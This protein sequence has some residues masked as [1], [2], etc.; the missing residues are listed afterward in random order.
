MLEAAVLRVQFVSPLQAISRYDLKSALI[1]LLQ[2]LLLSALT[3]LP[4]PVAS[5]SF[6]LTPNE[7]ILSIYPNGHYTGSFLT[8]SGMLVHW[9]EEYPMF[10]REYLAK[11]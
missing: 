7:C 10:P 3:Q 4:L 8:S 9:D 1:E 11:D 6:V 5:L 2:M